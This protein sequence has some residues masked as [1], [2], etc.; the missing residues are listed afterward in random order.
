MSRHKIVSDLYSKRTELEKLCGVSI[1]FKKGKRIDM[2]EVAN[3]ITNV[4]DR[5]LR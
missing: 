5:K 2:D 3:K 1:S 4:V